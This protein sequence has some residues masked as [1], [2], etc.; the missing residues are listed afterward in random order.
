MRS[1]MYYWTSCQQDS[2]QQ[3]EQWKEVYQGY[4]Q[5]P[6]V[7][8]GSSANVLAFLFLHLNLYRFFYLIGFML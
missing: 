3:Y 6:I 2:Y 1:H 7:A 4:F 8:M 5:K